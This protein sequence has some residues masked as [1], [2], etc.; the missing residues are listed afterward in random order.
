MIYDPNISYTAIQWG[1]QDTPA[2]KLRRNVILFQCKVALQAG[3]SIM[4]N[5]ATIS[6]GRKGHQVSGGLSLIFHSASPN[7]NSKSIR[8]PVIFFPFPCWGQGTWECDDYFHLAPQAKALSSWERAQMTQDERI[9]DQSNL[10]PSWKAWRARLALGSSMI[11]SIQKM[12][13]RVGGSEELG[14]LRLWGHCCW[15]WCFPNEAVSSC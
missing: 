6:T 10:F 7:G 15:C 2:S 8:F 5:L 4:C 12:I 14:F 11:L 1:S 9:G 13:L 3:G